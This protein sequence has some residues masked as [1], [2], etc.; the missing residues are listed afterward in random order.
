MRV[1][2]KAEYA[3]VAVLEL[4]AHEGSALPVSVKAIAER[5]DIPQRYLV[6]ILLQLKGAGFVASTRGTSGGYRLVLPPEDIS[7]ADIMTAIDGPLAE[8]YMPASAPNSP[9]VHAIASTWNEV[10]DAER[11]MLQQV[12]FAELVK[13]MKRSVENMYYI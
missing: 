12:T 2:A 13:R 10:L 6:Q 1:S 3:C 8:K 7:L 4:A 11:E 5:H 9:A